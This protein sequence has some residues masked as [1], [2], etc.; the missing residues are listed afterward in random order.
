MLL[1]S[2]LDTEE[3]VFILMTKT[4]VSGFP[5]NIFYFPLNWKF[6]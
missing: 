3:K 6:A 5:E 2:S 1:H 4:Q